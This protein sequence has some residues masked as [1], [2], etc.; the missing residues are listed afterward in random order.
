MPEELA[1]P[2]SKGLVAKVLVA[3]IAEN[4]GFDVGENVQ[5]PDTR[6]SS[7]RMRPDERRGNYSRDEGTAIVNCEVTVAVF[8]DLFRSPKVERTVKVLMAED[9]TAKLTV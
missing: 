1:P 4:C 8:D 7:L 6:S 5:H 3:N 2:P 9:P